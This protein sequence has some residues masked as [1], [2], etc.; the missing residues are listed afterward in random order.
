MTKVKILIWKEHFD[1]WLEGHIMPPREVDRWVVEKQNVNVSG[2]FVLFAAL[3]WSIKCSTKDVQTATKDHVDVVQPPCLFLH[4]V[5]KNIHSET[6]EKYNL[7]TMVKS[8]FRII[9]T[10]YTVETKILV[11]KKILVSRYVLQCY[12]ERHKWTS[13]KHLPYVTFFQYF[14]YRPTQQWHQVKYSTTKTEVC[15]NVDDAT[16][17]WKNKMSPWSIYKWE[18]KRGRRVST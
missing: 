14:A 17:W 12:R 11:K 18:P 4:Q 9:W 13:K 6:R 7:S 2:N 15:T 8:F 16:T 5:T 10:Y 1:C 3:N